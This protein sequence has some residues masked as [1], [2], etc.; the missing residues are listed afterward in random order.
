MSSWIFTLV[1][2]S[3]ITI[4]SLLVDA[5]ETKKNKYTYA[6]KIFLISYITIYLGLMF[7][8]NLDNS[9]CPEIEIGDAPF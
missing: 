9:N 3:I 6:A 7:G 5:N 4:L 2:S 8:L 1:L